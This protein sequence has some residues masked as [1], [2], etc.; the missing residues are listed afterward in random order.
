MMIT[1]H[2][3]PEKLPRLLHKLL[4]LLTFVKTM[5]MNFC[6]I[7]FC[8]QDFKMSIIQK[9]SY[10]FK[11]DSNDELH[12]SPGEI[13]RVCSTKVPNAIHV[14]LIN[15]KLRAQIICYNNSNWQIFFNAILF[16]FLQILWGK[17]WKFSMSFPFILI[18][19]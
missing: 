14:S 7:S 5:F 12:V 19:K 8:L 6:D 1:S 11:E 16:I 3:H 4:L 15:S 13:Q 17:F 2:F 10:F 18:Y 9:L